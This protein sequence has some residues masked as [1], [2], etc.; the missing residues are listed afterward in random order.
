MEAF[1][2]P[3]YKARNGPFKRVLRECDC[4]CVYLQL[5]QGNFEQDASLDIRLGN[6]QD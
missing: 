2:V 6:L 1:I 3:L 5:K 4:I